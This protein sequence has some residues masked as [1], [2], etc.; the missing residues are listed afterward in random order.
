[1]STP[2]LFAGESKNLVI[3]I[4]NSDGTIPNLVGSTF[5]WKL[6]V[7]NNPVEKD[8]TNGISILDEQ[9]GTVKVK[10]DPIDSKN[11]SGNF[12]HELEMTDSNG[13][14]NVVLTGILQIRTN[15]I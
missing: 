10:L 12:F 5:K 7:R 3:S 13:N 4:V 15:I 14:I 2:Y 8:S 11:L 1:M 6:D 9:A